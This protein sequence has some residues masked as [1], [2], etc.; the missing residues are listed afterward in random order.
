MEN[1]LEKLLNTYKSNIKTYLR[2]HAL[3]ILEKGIFGISSFVFYGIEQVFIDLYIDSVIRLIHNIPVDVKITKKNNDIYKYSDYH[4]EFDMYSDERHEQIKFIKQL[5]KSQ[6]ITGIP[7]IIHIKNLNNNTCKLFHN[8][9]ESTNTNIIIF[10]SSRY[11][12]NIDIHIRN[13]CELVNLIPTKEQIYT[14]VC[15]FH[16]NKDINYN[17]FHDIYLQYQGNLASIALRIDKTDKL[18][19]DKTIIE[20]IKDIKKSRSF[21][22]LNQKIRELSYKLFHINTPFTYIT[23]IILDEYRDSPKYQQLINICTQ[24]EHS[25][26]LVYKELFVYEKFFMDII[27]TLKARN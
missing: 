18:Y 24:S 12:K 4:F 3:S 2:P 16:S 13:K 20:T 22:I 19:I 21:L 11:L 9:V 6:S 8:I 7:H 26:H 5:Q 1:P 15:N 23:K 25:I 14:F 17:I 27:F 10:I